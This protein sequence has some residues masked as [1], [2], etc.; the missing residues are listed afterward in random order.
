MVAILLCIFLIGAASVSAQATPTPIMIGQ[1]QTGN[2]TDASGSIQYTL[3]VKS[4]QSVT[5]LAL[6]VTSGFAPTF[7]VLDPAGVVVFDSA[8]SGAQAIAQGTIDLASPGNYTIE[9]RS[10]NNTAGQF[11]LG[12]QAGAPLT[13]PTALVAGTPVGGSVDAKT[14]RQAY[15]FNGSTTDVLVLTVR[16]SDAIAGAAI[17]LRDADTDETLG[18]SGTGLGGISFRI[19]MGQRN[20]LLE[21]TSNGA[22]VAQ[23]FSVC[24]ASES[25]STTCPG[26]TAGTT[27]TEATAA[28][29]TVA[30]VPSE[31]PTFAPVAINPSGACEVAPARNN[32]VNVR[33]GAGTGFGIVAT[34]PATGTALVVGRLADNSW[35]QVNVSGKLGWVSAVVVIPGGNCAGVAVIVLPTAVPP[36]AAPV[37][38]PPSGGSGGVPSASG[39]GSSPTNVPAAPTTL[40][41]NAYST[42]DGLEIT[43]GD[44]FYPPPISQAISAGGKVDVSYL[45]GGCAGYASSA[46]NMI[47][48]YTGSVDVEELGFYFLANGGDALMIVRNP[49]CRITCNDNSPD[50]INPEVAYVNTGLGH[51]VRDGRYEIWIAYIFPAD[52][53]TR[54]GTLYVTLG[55]ADHP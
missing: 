33:S 22:S 23:A 30:G 17:A 51:A 45:G 31:T 21:I 2:L 54:Q 41:A 48:T 24:L 34:I 40:N 27:V 3:T 18:L 32:S 42:N 26:G 8:T 36:T 19:L 5:I 53:G 1:N 37:I 13:P 28:P 29:T 14:T 15:S 39:G 50:S 25:G 49:D 4:S 9:V 52:Y 7:R 6:A 44:T 35:Y 47:I 43:I 20:Y 11:L 10:A 12:I 38:A 16:D 46:P 55:A